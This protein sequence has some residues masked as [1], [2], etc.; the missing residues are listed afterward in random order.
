VFDT[1]LNTVM[2]IWFLLGIPALAVYVDKRPEKRN[3]YAFRA[4]AASIAMIL[5]SIAYYK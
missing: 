2:V 4:A 5:A 1:V 3:R